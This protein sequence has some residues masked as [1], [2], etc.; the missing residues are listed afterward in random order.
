MTARSCRR[1][2]AF[3]RAYVVLCFM[4][5]DLL[6]YRQILARLEFYTVS[7]N[8]EACA[9][10]HNAVAG[11][12]VAVTAIEDPPPAGWNRTGQEGFQNNPP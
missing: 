10:G 5:F 4:G 12:R 11:S 7:I 3:Q 9:W 8:R 2:P 1:G 6:A